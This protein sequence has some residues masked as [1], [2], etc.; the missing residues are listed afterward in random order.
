MNHGG[1]RYFVTNDTHIT[2]GDAIR[3]LGLDANQFSK[4]KK[5]LSIQPVTNG[6]WEKELIEKIKHIPKSF[7]KENGK[8][9]WDILLRTYKGKKIMEKKQ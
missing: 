9:D 6:I 8:I 2:T 3:F 4:L 7:T 1:N 5:I